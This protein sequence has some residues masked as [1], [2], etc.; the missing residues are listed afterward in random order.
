MTFK[1]QQSKETSNNKISNMRVSKWWLNIYFYVSYHFKLPSFN[2]LAQSVKDA[3]LYTDAAV[4]SQ[5]TH[6]YLS[7]QHTHVWFKEEVETDG[8]SV[9]M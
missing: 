1:K 4:R 9:S 6:T 8:K 5:T 2:T 3:P 7:L